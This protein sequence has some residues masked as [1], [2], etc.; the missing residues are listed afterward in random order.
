[1]SITPWVLVTTSLVATPVQPPALGLSAPAFAAVTFTE[2]SDEQARPVPPPQTA[3]VPR[4][5]SVG[6]SIVAGSNGAAG[7]VRY[8][9]TPTVGVD[10][11][12][13]YYRL[14]NYYGPNSSGSTFQVAPSVVVMLT[15]FDASRDV[16]LQPYLGGGI[17]Y[18]SS[19][20]PVTTP[21]AATSTTGTGGQAFG[22]VEMTF[23][24]TPQFGLTFEAAYFHLPAG[25]VGTGY[26]GGMNYL[27][28]VHFYV[29]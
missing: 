1:M 5:F 17:N 14:P 8:W 28:G 21:G 15:K 29:K 20:Q 26:I 11:T 23:K 18:V 13:G 2:T 9:F 10:M 7:S 4:T 3:S 19:S 6:G 22:G 12:V 25:F 24:D 16:N 27:L